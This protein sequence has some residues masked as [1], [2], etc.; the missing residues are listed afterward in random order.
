MRWWLRGLSAVLFVV[1]LHGEASAE[2][3]LAFVVGIN[4]Y[5]HLPPEAQLQRAA[6]DAGAVGDALEGLGFAVTRLTQDAS[7]DKILG[8]L[9][10]FTRSIQ[11]GDTVLFYYAGHGISLDDGNYLIPSDI[12]LLGPSDERIAKRYAIAEREVKQDL[13][14]AGARVTIVVLDACRNNPFPARGTR[15]IGSATRGLARIDATDGVYSL[16]SAREGQTA[17]DR[18]SDTDTERN[19]VFT[20]VFIKELKT[21]GV[22]LSELGDIVRDDVASL[23]RSANEEQVPAVSND[24][25]GARSVYLSGRAPVLQAVPAAPVPTPAMPAADEITWGFIKGTGDAAQIEAFLQRFPQS[26]LR[27]DAQARLAELRQSQ[28]AA[29]TP[30]SPQGDQSIGRTTPPDAS[31]AECDRLAA[32]SFDSTRP[33]G[34]AGQDN[35]QRIDGPAAV[36]ACRR[37]LATDPDNPRLEMQLGIALVASLKPSGPGMSAMPDPAQSPEIAEGKGLLKRAAERGNAAAMM[38]L[39]VT[40]VE[41]R[42]EPPSPSEATEGIDWIRKAAENGVAVADDY[43]GMLYEHGRGVSADKAQ[44]LAWYRKGAAAGDPRSRSDAERLGA[45]MPAD[46]GSAAAE[47][48]AGPQDPAIAECDRLAALQLDPGRPAGVPGISIDA[49][50]PGDAE[51]AVRA[52]RGAVAARPRDPRLRMQLG[53]ALI[54]QYEASKGQGNPEMVASFQQAAEAG[55]PAAM[56]LLGA[57]YVEEN[58]DE[59]KDKKAEGLALLHKAADR[60]VGFAMAILG[61]AYERGSGVAVD[62]TEALAW[63]RK[64]VAAGYEEAARDAERLAKTMPPDAG[65]A[66]ADV[67]AAAPDPS[68]A[69]CDRLTA[70]ETDPSRP[71]GV[72]GID[73]DAMKALDAAKA[74]P[75]CRAAVAARPQDPRLTMQ[76]GVAL[77]PRYTKA[78]GEDHAEMLA[79]LRR[80]A[81]MGY[82]AAMALLGAFYF[83]EPTEEFKDKRAEGLA[84]LRK[85]SDQGVGLAMG[86]LGDAYE[87][88]YEGVPQDKVQALALYRKAAAAGYP[89]AARDAER[90]AKAMPP[91]AGSVAEAPAG[92]TDPSVAE[93][94]RLAAWAG[95]PT[96]PADVAGVEPDAIDAATAEPACAAALKARPQDVRVKFQLGLALMRKSGSE[97][98]PSPE[99]LAAIREAAEGGEPAAALLMAFFLMNESSGIYD[100]AGGLRLLRKA[101]EGGV[102]IGELR[103]AD[104]LAL[105]DHTTKD[106]AEARLWYGKAAAAGNGEATAALQRLDKADGVAAPSGAAQDTPYVLPAGAVLQPKLNAAAPINAVAFSPDGRT[107]LMGGDGVLALWDVASGKEIRSFAGP[108]G[109][110][111]SMRFLGEGQTAASA[112]FDNVVKLWDVA[113][114]QPIRSFDNRDT[115]ANSVSVSPDGR[116]VA[117]SSGGPINLLDFSTGQLTRQLVGHRNAVNKAVFSPDGHT[118]AS[119]S[120]DQT[121]RL[122]TTSDGRQIR[123]FKGHKGY[124]EDVAFLPSGKMLLSGSDDRTMKLWSVATGKIVRTFTSPSDIYAV[125]VSA[126]GNTALSGHEDGTVRL[127]DIATGQVLR[128]FTGHTAAVVGVAFSPDGRTILSGCRDTTMKLW[129]IGSGQV[130]ATYFASSDGW[131]SFNADGLFVT[132]R[133]PGAAL[134]LKQGSSDL[135]AD[136]LFTHNRRDNLPDVLSSAQ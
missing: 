120:R 102:V 3:K 41:L 100:P 92:P 10:R 74:V 34:V 18:L 119:A 16:Y 99:T 19:S 126:D 42:G 11:P 131:G 52:C 24:L 39:G 96:K 113:T 49:I 125:A 23:A 134:S 55:Y 123:L 30:P 105:G 78:P 114:G 33:P 69:E 76:L 109:N 104:A 17:L 64:A 75:A 67:E 47:A 35:P 38:L 9:E 115:W 5:Q 107:A 72:A 40:I 26:R 28:V 56:A 118:L 25:I 32:M 101:A 71:A 68:I 90:L 20:R 13:R 128:L 66:P 86:I 106:L 2:S 31:L 82:P 91:D 7:L 103:L 132:S 63:Y 81:D 51:A 57:L 112:G 8:E 110:V 129:S 130:L 79:L 43:L 1:G 97:K 62:K 15:A 29:L 37:A 21:P 70:L 133:D 59:F 116:L 60:G 50:K 14:A 22:S 135:P 65:A 87:R 84:L 61:E 95:D 93:C 94:D 46:A 108:T 98:A 83:E 12:P 73:I 122:W 77:I 117:V 53:V 27:G 6:S 80:S 111:R 124:V 89:D 88:G 121:V 58:K 127:W 48:Q 136:D 36:P 44:A 45:T 4:A 54:P 85:A